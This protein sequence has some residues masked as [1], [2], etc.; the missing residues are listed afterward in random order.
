MAACIAA[1]G[2]ADHMSGMDTA[3]GTIVEVDSTCVMQPMDYLPDPGVRLD[4]VTV[5]IPQASA[6]NVVMAMLPLHLLTS[7]FAGTLDLLGTLIGLHPMACWCL[8]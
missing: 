6:P 8:A 2:H 5:G 1:R 3:D 7:L 4:G